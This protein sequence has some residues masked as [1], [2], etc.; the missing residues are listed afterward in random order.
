MLK[1]YT[2]NGLEKLKKAINLYEW[3]NAKPQTKNI[4]E[5]SIIHLCTGVVAHAGKVET[6]IVSFKISDLS[7]V[8][9]VSSKDY[10]KSEMII[11]HSINEAIDFLK[12]MDRNIF[13]PNKEMRVDMYD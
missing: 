1:Y 6:V 13:L 7:I 9:E 12:K 11:F 3:E 8:K 5:N 10:N 4:N 2:V